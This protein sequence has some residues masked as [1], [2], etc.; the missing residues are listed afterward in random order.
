TARGLMVEV[1]TIDMPSAAPAPPAVATTDLTPPVAV[2]TTRGGTATEVGPGPGRAITFQ[3]RSRPSLRPAPRPAGPAGPR[4]A[5][6]GGDADTQP[7][8]DGRLPMVRLLKGIWE[9]FRRKMAV[10]GAQ[11][12]TLGPAGR[13]FPRPAQCQGEH[14]VAGRPGLRGPPRRLTTC[15]T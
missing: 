1:F 2:A 4:P 11:G 6:S 3:A 15:S 8:A 10:P 14:P 13:P 12:R 9:M 5:A 7:P